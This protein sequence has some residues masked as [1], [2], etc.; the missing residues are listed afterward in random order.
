M[1][2]GVIPAVGP[3]ARLEWSPEFGIVVPLA[4]G[5][6]WYALG[7]RRLW[8]LGRSRVVRPWEAASFA[9]GWT[10]LAVA[11]VSPIHAA[12]ELLF[13]VHMVQHELLMT[14][15]APLL[16][17]GR[18]AVAMMWGMPPA[19]R[20]RVGHVLVMPVFRWVRHTATQP[21]IAWFVHAVVI[22]GWHIPALFQFALR[23]EPVHA[24]QHTTFI[25][26]AV[27]FWSAVMHP[28]QREGLGLSIL[29]LFTTAVHT[30]VLGA[31]IAVAR[32][33]WYPAYG[34]G[35]VA[36]G[37]TPMGDQQLAGLIMWIPA[38]LAYLIAALIVLWRLLRHTARPAL[39]R[40]RIML[41]S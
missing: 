9:A 1:L 29:L 38:N 10:I 6:V 16:I 15:A 3:S 18:P 21:V 22:W 27:L 8:A 34:T 30:A 23:S 4:L 7:A 32:T 20:T 24:L 5:A 25:V 17:A 36:W 19:A 40:D 33:P 14:V 41:A 13:S 28:R 2:A 11:L 26:S 37:L 35:A 39:R 12:S 31:L